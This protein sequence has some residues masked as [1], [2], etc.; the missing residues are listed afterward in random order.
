MNSH[1]CAPFNGNHTLKS[2]LDFGKGRKDGRGG[3]LVWDGGGGGRGGGAVGVPQV[4][5][6][7]G[8]WG[9]VYVL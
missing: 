2:D 4:R 1:S 7:G 3:G 5:V 9:A 6:H 8:G